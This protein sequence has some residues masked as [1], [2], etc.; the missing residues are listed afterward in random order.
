MNSDLSSW[1]VGKVT[2]LDGMFSGASK[3]A[4]VGLDSWDT[5]S[6][7]TLLDTFNSAVEMNVN[8]GGWSV[9]KGE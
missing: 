9:A 2:R 4:G 1:K 5:A 3:F 6:V 8:L 7:N